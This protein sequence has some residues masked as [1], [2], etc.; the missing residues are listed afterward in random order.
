[1]KETDHYA[2]L[3]SRVFKSLMLSEDVAAREESGQLVRA[4]STNTP[5]ALFG[6]FE[7]YFSA[8]LRERAQ[9][10]TYAYCLF[11]CFEN[12]VRELVSQRLAERK[13]DTW[14]TSSVPAKVQQRVQNKKQEIEEN[15]WH[16]SAIGADVNHTL[17]G[18]LASIIIAQWQEF[19]ELFPDQ[20][21]VQVRL[22]E[23]ERSR[24]VIAHG[25]VLPDSEIER[26]EQYLKDWVRQV[27]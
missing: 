24:N 5:L 1:M 9:R 25:N 20:Q 8:N 26:L 3:Y 19:E 17:F 15:K 4:D 14:W 7:A 10:M 22:N 21:W 18:D 12:A 23:L 2:T 13:G 6:D 16:E 11:F 27:P